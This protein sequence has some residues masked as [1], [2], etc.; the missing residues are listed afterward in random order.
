[1]YGEMILKIIESKV[2]KGWV[3]SDENETVEVWI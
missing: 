1:M 3:F 2:V